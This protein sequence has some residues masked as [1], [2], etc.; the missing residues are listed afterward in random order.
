VLWDCSRIDQARSLVEIEFFTY[1]VSC[2]GLLAKLRVDLLFHFHGEYERMQAVDYVLYI[3]YSRPINTQIWS[4]GYFCDVCL[5]SSP[6]LG[7]PATFH[8]STGYTMNN[9]LFSRCI[10]PDCPSSRAA[11][12]H[13]DTDEGRHKVHNFDYDGSTFFVAIY[14]NVPYVSCLIRVVR[15][16]YRLA[17]YNLLSSCDEY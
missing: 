5:T 15:K 14:V 8:S 6:S 16:A 12:G 9:Q 2:T 3:F 10:A 4:H 17:G 11:S 13:D 1:A 7:C